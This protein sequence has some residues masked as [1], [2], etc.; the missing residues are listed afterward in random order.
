MPKVNC[1][2]CLELHEKGESMK[3]HM[4]TKHPGYSEEISKQS[5]ALVEH[6][7]QNDVT[8]TWQSK[9]RGITLTVSGIKQNDG[10]RWKCALCGKLYSTVSTLG[11]NVTNSLML[12]I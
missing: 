10:Q 1:H 9:K 12:S 5:N 8:I 3:I 4:E 2:V 7:N 6:Q 11:K